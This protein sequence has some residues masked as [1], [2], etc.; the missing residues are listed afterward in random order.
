[1]SQQFSYKLTTESE[2]F[3]FDF[4]NVLGDSETITSAT[5]TILVKDGSDSNPS[6]ML[7]GIPAV[8]GTRVAQQIQG[9]LDQVT[10]RIVLTITTSLS[11]T[12]TTVADLPVYSPGSLE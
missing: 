5:F 2:P 3:L 11:N 9:G 6:A 12:L 8:I 7:S 1:M 10:Y 4:I